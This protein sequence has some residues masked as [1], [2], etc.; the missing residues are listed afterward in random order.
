MHS[1]ADNL[2]TSLFEILRVLHFFG[3]H[4]FRPSFPHFAISPP[5]QFCIQGH[6]LSY[7]VWLFSVLCFHVFLCINYLPILLFLPDFFIMYYF[8]RDEWDFC[9][10]DFGLF[11]LVCL[12]YRN[13]EDEIW[14]LCISISLPSS[15]FVRASN[16]LLRLC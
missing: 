5:Q 12:C 3:I 6:F 11:L 7:V 16:E 14:F 8:V 1:S 4:C 13:I 10:V 2:F 15:S 9:S